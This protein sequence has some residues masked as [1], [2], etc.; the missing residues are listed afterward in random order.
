M[1]K[2]KKIIIIAAVLLVVAAVILIIV[3]KKSGKDSYR[4]LKVFNVEGKAN[5]NREGV[6][7][8]EPYKNMVL[9][10]GDDITLETGTLIIQADNDKYIYLEEGT[11]I[12]LK[13]SGGKND[14]KTSIDLK[15]GAITND[16]QEKLSDEEGYE[17]NTPNST[18]SVYGTM[19]RV[20]VYE[21]NGIKYT[22]VSVFDGEVA[23]YLVYK[24]GT[25]SDNEVRV[26]KDKEV[27]IYEDDTTTD[28]LFPPRDI[29]YSDLPDELL[30]LLKDAI[31]NGRDLL[32]TIEAIDKYLSGIVTVTFKYNGSVF[33]TQTIKKGEK[34]TEPSLAPAA[35]GSWDWDFSKPVNSDIE[36]EWK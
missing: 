32:V 21:E 23:S 15:R 4:I 30:E 7:D 9:K 11:E 14:G 28:Y 17:V 19:F 3:L 10:S 35:S 33:G 25:K 8:I 16:I 1:S 13:A 36:I 2:K 18:M 34:V 31:E 27:I 5:V 26:E 12:V 29:D 6:G 20:E 22:R 24:D